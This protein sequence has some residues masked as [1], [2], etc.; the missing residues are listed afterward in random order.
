MVGA[1]KETGELDMAMCECEQAGRECGVRVYVG[2]P[3]SGT[4]ICQT[5]LLKRAHVDIEK[6]GTESSRSL[7]I[8]G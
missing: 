3:G 8:I 6:R 4:W 1:V 7:K 5:E 2:T